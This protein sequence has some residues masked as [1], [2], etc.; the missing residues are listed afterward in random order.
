MSTTSVKE[1]ASVLREIV[2]V[3]RMRPNFQ[4]QEEGFLV[5]AKVFN[6]ANGKHE[7]TLTFEVCKISR[8]EITG[9]KLKRVKGDTWAYKK[10]SRRCC[11]VLMVRPCLML[12][13]AAVPGDPPG[14]QAL[15]F[16][17]LISAIQ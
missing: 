2:R 10:V 4:V 7:M 3:L 17:H 14:G 6:V 1:P 9:V 12:H 5:K 15:A 8:M 16:L 11:A 13:S